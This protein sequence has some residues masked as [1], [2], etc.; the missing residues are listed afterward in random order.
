MASS[1]TVSLH[2]CF[3]YV[4]A[5]L[6]YFCGCLIIFYWKSDVMN[7]MCNSRI[8]SPSLESLAVYNRDVVIKMTLMNYFLKT[9]FFDFLMCADKTNKQTVP[10]LCSWALC[11]CTGTYLQHSPRRFTTLLSLAQ[12][13][14]ISQMQECRAFSSLFWGCLLFVPNL[15]LVVSQ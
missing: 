11:L 2:F 9:V 3:Y 12:S 7:I 8:Y 15:L 13:L 6:S 5:I 4:P 10:C 1:G 14:K